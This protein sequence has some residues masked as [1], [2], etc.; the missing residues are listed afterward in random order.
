MGALAGT[1]IT[2]SL[3]HAAALLPALRLEPKDAT[4]AADHGRPEARTEG[5]EV[6]DRDRLNVSV[7]ARLHA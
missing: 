7:R 5:P 6:T 4:A 2:L 3:I 1:K